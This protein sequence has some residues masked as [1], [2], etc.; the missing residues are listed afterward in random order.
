[1]SAGHPPG[2]DAPSPDR[3]PHE[4]PPVEALPPPRATRSGARADART[5][6]AL[7][8]PVLFTPAALLLADRPMRVFDVPAILV[9]V[10]SVWL[11]GIGLTWLL[12]R[13]PR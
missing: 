6:V 13:P 2:A 1:M 3:T 4:P 5:V 12:S 9:Y 8:G 7:A 10:F 11:V